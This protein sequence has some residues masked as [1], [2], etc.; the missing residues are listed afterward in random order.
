MEDKVLEALK[1]L[2]PAESVSEISDAVAEVLANAVK[3]AKQEYSDKLEEAYGELTNE[4]D[5]A[6]KTAEKG[7]QEAWGIIQDL[8][9]RIEKQK[10]EFEKSLEEGYAEAYEELQKERQKNDTIAAELYEEYDRRSAKSQEYVV[11]KLDEFL[12]LRGAE[13]YEQARRD[14]ENNPRTAEHKVAIDK[15]MD[16][17]L[18]YASD[19]D[20]AHVNNHKIEEMG[21]SLDQMK[22]QV[23]L[24]EGRNVKLSTENTKLSEQ[25]RAAAEVITEARNFS[26]KNERKE[27]SSKAKNVSGRGNLVSEGVIPEYQNSRQ[28]AGDAINEDTTS[29]L[30]Q[31]QVL[32]GIKKTS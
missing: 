3:E 8:H 17:A 10:E 26:L 15:I 19:D 14:H 1:H 23:R 28:V 13:I 30:Y 24:L 27:R 22:A 4:L 18:E 6:E 21:R 12:K 9:N 16:I 31:M 25:V 29:Q 5:T 20:F 32:A 7:Y 2:L 11:D